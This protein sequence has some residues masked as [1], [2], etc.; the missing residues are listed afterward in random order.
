MPRIKSAK[1]LPM[2]VI[3]FLRAMCAVLSWTTMER[4]MS[5]VPKKASEFSKMSTTAE[6]AQ[7]SL[8][9]HIAPR[10]M[11]SVKLRLRHAAAVLTRRNWTPNRVRDLWY[12]DERA[13]APRWN[14]IKDLEEL[15]GLRCGREELREVDNLIQ[16]ADGLLH[17]ADA[18]FYRPFIAAL[19]ALM[20]APDR[21]GTED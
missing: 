21:S 17:G 12:R 6:F 18:D 9:N 16:R 20:G 2:L 13:S 7:F 8:R 19:R 3:S 5:E 14:E 1:T 15:T 4:N 10:A 11:G